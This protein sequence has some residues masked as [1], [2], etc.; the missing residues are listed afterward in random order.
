MIAALRRI[1]G[2]IY[3][4]LCLYRRSWPRV[5]ELAYWPTLELLIWGFT[6][7][8][9]MKGHADLA[10]R[11][12][13]ALIGG[14]LLWEVA[15]RAQMGVTISF[16]EEIWSRNLGHVFVSP[17]RP[18]EMVLALLGV[19]VLRTVVGLTPAAGIAFFL[20]E[21]NIFT[22]GLALILFVANLFLM[23]WWLALGV[24]SLLF[25]Y[26]ASAEAL[27]W[28]LAFGL[29]PVACVFYPVS[30]LPPWLRPVA[31]ALPA[32][33]IFAGMRTALYHH[34]TDIGQLAIAAGLNLFWMGCAGLIFALQ[35]RAARRSGALVTIGE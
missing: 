31:E 14:V 18:R 3:R 11:T 22:F 24:I 6:A 4:H 13:G 27:A 17:L 21:F 5:L 7:Q 34:K 1:W 16:L 26:G 10:I 19:S 12:A 28:T 8:F 2:L 33:H 9:V 23:G 29:T 32:A 35:F 15:L 20:Y 30:V 25:R